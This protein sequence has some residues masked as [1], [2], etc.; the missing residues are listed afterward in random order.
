MIKKLSL[1]ILVAFMCLQI[2]GCDSQGI[3]CGE[4]KKV[5]HFPSTYGY[6]EKTILSFTNNK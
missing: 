3:V 2:V 6:A 5:E 1:V 4:V